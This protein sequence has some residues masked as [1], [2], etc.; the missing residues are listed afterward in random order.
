ME[1]EI[2]K[3]VAPPAPAAFPVI[4]LV[5]SAG[6]L[7]AVSRVLGPLP[8]DLAAAI[9]VLIH[10]SPDRVSVIAEIL[11][12]RC[13]MPVAAAEH[14][15]RLRPATVIVAPP[16]R[17]VLIGP[18]PTVGLIVSGAVPP[19]RPSADLLLATLA[20]A[21]G[22]SAIAVVLSGGGH[23]GATGATA[24][25]R[26]GGTVVASDAASSESFS[27]P[28]ATIERDHAVDHVVDLD[29]IPA[30]LTELV[31]A[32]QQHGGRPHSGSK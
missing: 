10:Q 23:D 26:Y 6:G 31:A 7:E 9:V 18:G 28:L 16:G 12:G 30:L 14:D 32:A 13:A 11:G 15:R 27:M 2:P 20:T 19:S 1:R 24:V 25:H 21:V 8:G 4:A 17:H 22:P 29:A 5:A 3:P